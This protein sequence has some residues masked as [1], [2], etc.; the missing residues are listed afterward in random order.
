MALLKRWSVMSC[1]SILVT[2]LPMY[3]SASASSHIS[4]FLTRHALP[5]FIHFI[6]IPPPSL[7][8]KRGI[9]ILTSRDSPLPYYNS[10]PDPIKG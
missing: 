10:F 1:V 2:P 7:N 5:I 8:G 4:V 9:R 3:M 6:Q